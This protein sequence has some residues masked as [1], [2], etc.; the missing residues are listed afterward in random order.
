MI[1]V[2]GDVYSRLE[3]IIN[4]LKTASTFF[5]S[6]DTRK[7]LDLTVVYNYRDFYHKLYV[8]TVNK[9]WKDMGYSLS[10]GYYKNYALLYINLQGNPALAKGNFDYADGYQPHTVCK[11]AHYMNKTWLAN[12]AADYWKNNRGRYVETY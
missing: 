10:R 3:D 11:A 5:A 9:S 7:Q 12:I 2:Y 1:P 6:M 8:W 4:D